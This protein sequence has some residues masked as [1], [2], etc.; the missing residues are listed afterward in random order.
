MDD[1]ASSHKPFAP[2]RYSEEHYRALFEQTSDYVLILEFGL[3]DAAPIIVDASEA[4]FKKH[5]Y[6][7]EE[8]IGKSISFIDKAMTEEILKERLDL[9]H[10]GGITHFESIHTCKDGSTF[11]ADVALQHVYID[12]RHLLYSVERDISE[13]KQTERDLVESRVMLENA[14][15]GTIF[16]ISKVVEARDPYTSGHEQQVE[17]LACAIA[18]EMGLDES[19]SEGIRIGALI[20]DIGKIQVPIEILNKPTKLSHIEF[21]MVKQ[22]PLV[23]YK[24]LKDIPFPWPVALIVYQHHERMDGSGYPQGLKGND[25]LLEARVVAVA[26]VVDSMASHRP[27]RDGLGIDL[28]LEEI[29]LNR[30]KLYDVAVVDACLKLFRKKGYR[31]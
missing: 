4:A 1:D 21:E 13:K 10:N 24:V 27:Y 3:P 30:D 9:V 19:A 29:S 12:G 25:I 14:L 7:R 23:G 5:G 11:Y 22:H 18:N 6:T 20:H 15:A 2:I 31:I 16:A 28:A 8:M 17:K 26:D